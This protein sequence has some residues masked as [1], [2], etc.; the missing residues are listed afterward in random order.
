METKQIL[1]SG[2]EVKL[3]SKSGVKVSKFCGTVQ[4]CSLDKAKFL[5]K[6]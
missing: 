5:K 3:D 2:V 1:K 6:H 4:D